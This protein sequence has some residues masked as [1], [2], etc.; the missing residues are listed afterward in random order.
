MDAPPALG[1]L[2]AVP[3]FHYEPIFAQEVR[4]AFAEF[5]PTAVALECPPEMAHELD[6]A[7]SC[8]PGPVASRY[9]VKFW[10]FVPG[11]SMVEAYRL[12][13]E[14]G[15]S[16]HLV[17]RW[18]PKPIVRP[19][20]PP[21]PGVE[22]AA[23]VGD[24]FADVVGALEDSAGQPA[25]ED[26]AREDC[27][28][29]HL[30]RLM[31][32]HERVL[33]VGGMAHWP[34]MRA[35][36]VGGGLGPPEASKRR[37]S[38]VRLGLSPSALVAA[39]GRL[40]R[41]VHR[42]AVEPDAYEET[43]AIR[44]LA[45]DAVTVRAEIDY[46]LV[47]AGQKRKE[48]VRAPESASPADVAKMLAYAR[49]LRS[50][51]AVGD[52]PTLMDLLDA[53]SGVVGDQYAGRLYALAMQEQGS[54]ASRA[55]P[56]L[57]HQ[58]TE[59]RSGYRHKGRWVSVVPATGERA[60]SRLGTIRL[61]KATRDARRDGEQNLPEP[62]EGDKTGW[63]AVRAETSRF[64]ALVTYALR[65]ASVAWSTQDRS[66]AFESGMREGVDARETLRHWAEGTVFVRELSPGRL[67]I[68]NGVIDFTSEREDSAALRGCDGGGWNDP[69][70]DG[71][72]TVSRVVRKET[73]RE[74]PYTLRKWWREITFV[75]LDRNT[76]DSGDNSES[77]YERV[78]QPIFRVTK[79]KDDHLYS[80]L[81][82]MFESCQR[83]PLAYFSRYVPSAR[84]RRIA[85]KHGVRLVHVPLAQIPAAMLER[86]QTFRLI[87]LTRS[88]YEAICAIPDW[89]KR[90]W[91]ALDSSDG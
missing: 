73:Q 10:P 54:E 47:R 17:D 69:A 16:V 91:W 67:P 52:R 43:A 90:L 77:V 30:A 45:L 65:R 13:R 79:G 40:P 64:K 56:Q 80:W 37:V 60:E 36:L 59:A 15:V 6:W 88:Q 74:R 4:R 39:T 8:W 1:N 19:T 71:W 68:T 5:R 18:S 58:I 25:P 53:A 48:G 29:R 27:M 2:L 72:G 7:L 20:Q 89:R 66:A 3:S 26:L 41:L 12:A 31:A 51:R 70:F 78:I 35:L 61:E 57:E 14:R 46:E 11:D 75:T 34:R 87:C 63:V 44:A 76:W 33:W 81:G 42:Y 50:A 23:R 28:A 38:F 82:P 84:I 21:L 83:K 62:A 55:L 32:T 9:G 24:L 49:N 22:C 86:N 85:A